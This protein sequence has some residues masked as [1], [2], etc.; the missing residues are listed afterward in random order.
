MTCPCGT[1]LRM[2]SDTRQN[3]RQTP[4]QAGMVVAYPDLVTSRSIQTALR[5]QA[6]R[7][8]PSLHCQQIR[9]RTAALG[10]SLLSPRRELMPQMLLRS[11]SYP[12]FPPV[13]IVSKAQDNPSALA[14]TARRRTGRRSGPCRWS[15]AWMTTIRL[16]RR[17]SEWSR[18]RRRLVRREV[19]CDVVAAIRREVGHSGSDAPAVTRDQH[20]RSLRGHGLPSSV[21]ASGQAMRLTV[22]LSPSCT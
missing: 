10:S 15:C 14:N 20:D 18:I 13:L 22:R 12:A 9:C 7:Q 5:P 19:H 17:R 2:T 21:R 3:R 6:S 11:I 1:S 4:L 8:R 16:H